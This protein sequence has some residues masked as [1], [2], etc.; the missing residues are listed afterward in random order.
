MLFVQWDCTVNAPSCRFAYAALDL[1][2]EVLCKDRI[3]PFL[4]VPDC[5]L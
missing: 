2:T 1:P 5:L 4:S 3:R